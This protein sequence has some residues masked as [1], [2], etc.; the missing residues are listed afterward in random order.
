MP[1]IVCYPKLPEAKRLADLAG[2]R[3]DLDQI[4][5]Y[6]GVLDQQIAQNYREY[7]VWEAMTAAIAAAYGRC[8]NEGVRER[9]PR[10]LLNS[11]PS[12][13]RATHD[14]LIELRN[15]HV[16][17]SVN[18][19]EHNYLVVRVSYEAGRPVGVSEISVQTSRFI[20]ISDGELPNVRGLV[21]WV[22]ASVDAAFE[23]ERA[24]IINAL[25]SADLEQLSLHRAE[26]FID[27]LDPKANSRKRSTQ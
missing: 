1:V 23:A 12:A 24:K 2:I 14:Y 9:L 16:A 15:K 20:P 19:Y 3:D 7:Y 18:E 6:L 17:H 21:D 8:F 27:V 25:S 22:R 11:V 10:T 5:G 26:P 4:R 13:A